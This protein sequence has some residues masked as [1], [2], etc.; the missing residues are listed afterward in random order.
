[1]KEMI[2]KKKLEGYV[3]LA[4][5]GQMGI[6]YACY[7]KK[8]Q[9]RALKIIDNYVSKEDIKIAVSNNNVGTVYEFENGGDITVY[10][11]MLSTPPRVL[12]K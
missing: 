11:F 4:K 5:A 1:M 12:N 6:M 7:T 2:S 9:K 10:C 3:R 8:T